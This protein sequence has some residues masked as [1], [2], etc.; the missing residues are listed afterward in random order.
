VYYTYI[1]EGGVCKQV[2][3]PNYCI[4]HKNC[5]DCQNSRGCIFENNK[6]RNGT[7]AEQIPILKNLV[8]RC[9]D[10]VKVAHDTS[11]CGSSTV[12]VDTT[13]PSTN[14]PTG[15]M[16]KYGS[17]LYQITSTTSLI[18]D[19]LH[20][21]YS[22]SDEVYVTAVLPD[23]TIQDVIPLLS[24]RNLI[25]DSASNYYEYD[26]VKAKTVNIVYR[27][28]AYQPKTVFSY[29]LKNWKPVSESSLVYMFTLIMG[30]ISFT[31]L[32]V[33]LII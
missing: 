31:I 26:I 32:A 16:P 19:I 33:I 24:R 2:G 23:G 3:D 5:L 12:D 9:Q 28:T 11:K 29:S 30:L 20:I 1:E 7:I 15:D 17:C 6:C 25:N 22:D 27:S 18:N 21:T 4:K 13:N 14:V 10:F 8:D